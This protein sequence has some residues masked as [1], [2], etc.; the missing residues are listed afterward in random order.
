MAL[1]EPEPKKYTGG[2]EKKKKKKFLLFTEVK[3]F[4]LKITDSMLNAKF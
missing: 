4:K 2:K 1:K 3:L